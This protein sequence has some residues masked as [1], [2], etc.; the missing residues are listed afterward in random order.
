MDITP[1]PISNQTSH[2]DPAS[3]SH[4]KP[5]HTSAPPPPPSPIPNQTSPM[6]PVPAISNQTNKWNP[7]FPPTA[8]PW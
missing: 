5:N 3:A 8:N 2:M 1:P 4:P 6:D 7:Q